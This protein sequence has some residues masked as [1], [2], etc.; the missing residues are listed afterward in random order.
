M[1][2][3][4]NTLLTYTNLIEETGCLEWTRC[5]NSD[6]YA[7]A[8]IDG[9]NNGKV[10]RVVYELSTGKDATGLVV[11]HK[12][13]NPKCINPDHLEIGAPRDNMF[14]RDMRERSGTAKLTHKEVLAIRDLY[15]TGK[16]KQR[17][18]A[19]IFEVNHR[20]VS[21]IIC[22]THFKYVKHVQED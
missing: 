13:D 9:Y 15:A 7:R 17:E 4:L 6:G 18:L 19:N 16:Y 12:C 10:H 1:E 11:R 14:D 21:S 2:K 5:L 22:R 8:V 3:N 20:T